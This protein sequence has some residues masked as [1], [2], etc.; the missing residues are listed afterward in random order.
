[1]REEHETT[2]TQPSDAYGYLHRRIL[3]GK[4]HNLRSRLKQDSYHWNRD[5]QWHPLQWAYVI[6]RTLWIR[7]RL[8][9]LPNVVVVDEKNA[10][11]SR[12]LQL[13]VYDTL[14]NVR[15]KPVLRDGTSKTNSVGPWRSCPSDRLKPCHSCRRENSSKRSR[16]NL[17]LT[18]NRLHLLFDP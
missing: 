15:T 7:D 3:L 5:L 17:H 2:H 4:L 6:L 12:L 11:C 14:H 10:S 13:R 8:E 1:M 9:R 16:C 18:A